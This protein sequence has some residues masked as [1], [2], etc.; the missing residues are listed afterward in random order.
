MNRE[1][2]LQDYID[3]FIKSVCSKCNYYNKTMGV[4]GGEILPIER[5]ILKNLEGRGTC[6]DIKELAEQLK[7]VKN[8]NRSNK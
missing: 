3:Y 2:T 6:S 7:E 4:C 8:D 5:A 1:T